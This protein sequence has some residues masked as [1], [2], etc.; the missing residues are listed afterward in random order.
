[1]VTEV[2]EPVL[3][4]YPSLVSSVDLTRLASKQQGASSK[5]QAASKH[6]RNAD[7]SHLRSGASDSAKIL[8]DATY[9][10]EGQPHEVRAGSSTVGGEVTEV[11]YKICNLGPK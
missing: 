1:M 3:V 4:L 5:A 11:H 6:A 8:V 7:T 9:G 10:C 2:V